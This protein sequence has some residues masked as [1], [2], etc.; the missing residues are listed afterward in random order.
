MKE[1]TIYSYKL[2]LR[3]RW[4]FPGLLFQLLLLG[5]SLLG[6]SLWLPVALEQLLVSSYILAGVPVAHF[7]LFRLYTH[8]RSISPGTTPDMLFS[9]WWGAGFRL[10]QPLA[11]YRGAEWTVIL[12]SLLLSA[13]LFVWLPLS[14]G[15]TLVCGAI[16][17][18]FPRLLILLLSIRQPKQCRVKYESASVAFLL[19]DG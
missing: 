12:G 5:A 17:F 6:V 3:F 11:L 18:A 15:V 2:L 9:A 16:V 8:I 4:R 1:Q 13:A 10:P 19:T 7:L 14:F